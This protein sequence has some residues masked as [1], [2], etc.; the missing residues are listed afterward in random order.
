MI[1]R[2]AFVVNVMLKLGEKLQK[3]KIFTLFLNDQYLGV[4]NEVWFD[5]CISLCQFSGAWE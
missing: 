2:L 4:I 1:S 5:K 3:F